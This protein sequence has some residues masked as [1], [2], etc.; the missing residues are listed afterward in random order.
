M[1]GL[2][3]GGIF[4]VRGRQAPPSCLTGSGQIVNRPS[5]WKLVK[6]HSGFVPPVDQTVGWALSNEVTWSLQTGSPIGSPWHGV[7]DW[8][9]PVRVGSMYS[10]APYKP[11]AM[12][13]WSGPQEEDSAEKV[14]CWSLWVDLTLISTIDW[15]GS[16]DNETSLSVWNSMSLPGTTGQVLLFSVLSVILSES[17]ILFFL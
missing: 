3:E 1:S 5:R 11:I 6:V 4:V 15:N 7:I 8:W 14:S 10:R 13:R 12:L 9:C 2:L 16:L 17:F